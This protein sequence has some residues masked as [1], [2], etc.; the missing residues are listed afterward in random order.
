MLVRSSLPASPPA[1]HP[2]SP[3]L[4][5]SPGKRLTASQRIIVAIAIALTVG[6]VIL[7]AVDAYRLRGVARALDAEQVTS[8]TGTHA[9]EGPEALKQLAHALA[10][11]KGLGPALL[12]ALDEAEG[13]K[14]AINK[15][16]EHLPEKLQ[17]SPLLDGLVQAGSKTESEAVTIIHAPLSCIQVAEENQ[18]YVVKDS[19]WKLGPDGRLHRTLTQSVSGATVTLEQTRQ[20]IPTAQSSVCAWSLWKYSG[21]GVSLL[22]PIVDA[23]GVPRAYLMYDRYAED[24]SDAAATQRTATAQ[25]KVDADA[26]ARRVDAYRRRVAQGALPIGA[27]GAK[28]A[29]WTQWVSYV[30]L[31]V[32]AIWPFIQILARSVFAIWHCVVRRRYLAWPVRRE[33]VGVFICVN[34]AV[35]VYS[36]FKGYGRST[37]LLAVVADHWLIAIQGLF[38]TWAVYLLLPR[39]RKPRGTNNA[40][41]VLILGRPA[42]IPVSR[43]NKGRLAGAVF[44]CLVAN[45]FALVDSWTSYT[46]NRIG[47]VHFWAIWLWQ[48]LGCLLFYGAIF[49]RIAIAD[50][51]YLRSWRVRWLWPLASALFVFS[52]FDFVIPP[53]M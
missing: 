52:I 40:W 38:L 49:F 36:L 30:I 35:L 9:P 6:L 34:F 7:A 51:D 22:Y 53:K 16:R 32:A 18:A 48:N 39:S 27:F 29:L 37:S 46:T 14:K 28:L 4:V 44:L 3:A 26:L 23:D 15:I 2:S 41:K 11:G 50:Y 47:E 24:Y 1:V 31:A 25:W 42:M 13:L 17:R 12:A 19:R 8:P 21:G 5:R 20:G 10:D 43:R 33:W 45:V